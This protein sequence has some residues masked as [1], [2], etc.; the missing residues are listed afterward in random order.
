MRERGRF[1]LQRLQALRIDKQKLPKTSSFYQCPQNS[2][3]EG[4]EKN[5][6]CWSLFFLLHNLLT[7]DIH[8]NINIYLL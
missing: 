3:R 4:A 5:I 2:D 6:C 1:F 7:V 8:I